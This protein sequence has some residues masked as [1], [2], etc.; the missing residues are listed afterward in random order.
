MRFEINIDQASRGILRVA[1]IPELAREP[2]R[3]ALREVAALVRADAAATIR[4]RGGRGHRSIAGAPPKTDTGALLRS[5]K[6][7]LARKKRD[8]G[9]KAYVVAQR[10]G[11]GSVGNF[12]GFMLESGTRSMRAR[13]FLVP[14]AERHAGAFRQR[15]EE[16]IEA[17]IQRGGG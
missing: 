9:E 10:I 8:R 11:Y 14:A 12:Y 6:V 16:I 4:S 7:T 1:L 2:V 13:P 3:E 5:L 17:A 15:I